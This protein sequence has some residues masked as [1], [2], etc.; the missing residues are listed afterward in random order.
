MFDPN[1]WAKNHI[2]IYKQIIASTETNIS[3]LAYIVSNN[4]IEIIL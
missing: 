3:V 2:N 1:I 4:K